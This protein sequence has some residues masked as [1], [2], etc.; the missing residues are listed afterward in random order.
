MAK[1]LLHGVVTPCHHT[2]QGPTTPHYKLRDSTH[3]SEYAKPHLAFNKYPSETHLF[4]FFS[5]NFY[6]TPEILWLT[7]GEA[8]FLDVFVN[9]LREVALIGA[10]RR[11]MWCV[12]WWCVV[13][14]L[15][16]LTVIITNTDTTVVANISPISVLTGLSIWS[17]N[18]IF[19]LEVLFHLKTFAE[20]DA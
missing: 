15:S 8:V 5:H 7:K 20:I 2:I 14:N 11:E 3:S 4:L 1:S 13:C 6:F 10:S 17:K 16:S 18:T 9:K 19:L 12:I